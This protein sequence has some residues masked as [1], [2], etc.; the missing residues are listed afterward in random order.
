M[1]DFTMLLL[2]AAIAS[3]IGTTAVMAGV[4]LHA[5]TSGAGAAWAVCAIAASAASFLLF[6]LFNL[7]HTN[8]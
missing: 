1:S 5:G 3:F 2:S 4:A 6:V 8:Q 7:C